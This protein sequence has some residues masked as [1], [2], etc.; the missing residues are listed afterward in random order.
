MAGPQLDGSPE[1]QKKPGQEGGAAVHRVI[2]MRHGEC[3][4]N[5]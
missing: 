4:W 2:F 1:P 5:R 3:E